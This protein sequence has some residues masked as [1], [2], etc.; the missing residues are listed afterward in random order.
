V[1]EEI[2]Q[3][4]LARGKGFGRKNSKDSVSLSQ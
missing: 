4:Y 3:K 1:E 2:L